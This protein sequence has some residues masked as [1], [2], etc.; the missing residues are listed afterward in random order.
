MAL[1]ARR[2]G[3]EHLAQHEAARGRHQHSGLL[4]VGG[5]TLGQLLEFRAL[6]LETLA[7]LGV[8][9][10]DDLVDEAAIGGKIRKVARAAQQQ[11]ILDGL[12]QVAVRTLDRTV[13]VRDATVVTGWFYKILIAA[14]QVLLFV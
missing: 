7:V 5:A 3:V 4:V 9:A 11:R 2:D 6:E 1:E 12:L 10:P 8:V 14:G 13:L